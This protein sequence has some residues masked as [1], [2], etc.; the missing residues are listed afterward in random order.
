M[1]A[2]TEESVTAQIEWFTKEWRRWKGAS[3]RWFW[4][5]KS[6]RVSITALR[7]AAA[8]LKINNPAATRSELRAQFAAAW[9]G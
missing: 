9:V 6:E 8:I 4:C 2:T 7:A 3:F 1:N 5:F